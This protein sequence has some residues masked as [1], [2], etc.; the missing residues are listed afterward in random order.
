MQGSELYLGEFDHAL[1]NQCRVTLPSDWRN[2]DGGTEL[3]LIPARE[4]AL[5][6]LPLAT[7]M[8]FVNDAKK[9]AIANPK[10][11]MAFA[12][13]GALSRR[14]RCDKQGRI[15]LDRKMLDGIGVSGQIKLIG[16]LT[17]IRLCAPQ[18]WRPSENGAGLDS[19]LDE[20]QKVSDG[21]TELH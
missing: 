5:V 4:G 18:N 15:A 14:C 16:A 13:L 19:C 11:Q 21:L 6:L 10:M 12:R 7:F 8:A 1:D 3:V 20:I 9:L 2:R 17:H